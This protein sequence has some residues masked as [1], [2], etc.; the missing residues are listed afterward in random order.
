LTI[1]K[2]GNG[3]GLI[4]NKTSGSGNAVTVTGTAEATTLVKTGGVSTEFLK[5]DGSVTSLGT[6]AISLGGTANGLSY[7]NG[8]YRLH[9][10]NASNGGV[11][12][13]GRDTIAGLKI[14]R[15]SLYI[16]QPFPE[17]AGPFMLRVS[18]PLG[19]QPVSFER[20]LNPGTG[21]GRAIAYQWVSANGSPMQISD[22]LGV[23]YAGTDSAGTQTTYATIEALAKSVATNKMWGGFEDWFADGTDLKANP[24]YLTDHI[25]YAVRYPRYRD[26]SSPYMF[27]GTKTGAG[28]IKGNSFGVADSSVIYVDKNYRVG[29][30]NRTPATAFDVVGGIKSSTLGSTLVK[31]VSGV[32]TDAVASDLSS[33]GAVLTTTNQSVGGI[34]TFT[35]N[36]VFQ[37]IDPDSKVTIYPNYSGDAAGVGIQNNAGT[38]VIELNG[39]TGEIVSSTQ[40]IVSTPTTSAGGYDAL[41]RNTSTGVVEKIGMASGTYTPTLTNGT[42]VASS[43]PF[44]CQYYRI[45]NEVTVTGRIGIT[46]T[47]GSTVA[48]ELGISLPIA[49]ALTDTFDLNGGGWAT[50]YLAASPSYIQSDSGNDR[51]SFNFT[52]L[53]SASPQFTFSFT[54]IVK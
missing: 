3:E 21:L 47:S 38:F 11:L 16:G 48:T 7:L 53:A 1:T 25:P 51:A 31:S 50:N 9:K 34:K 5:A 22:G 28:I 15:D 32:L 2:G 39:S 52:A 37:G 14:I 29:I 27:Y 12:T 36:T 18:T 19:T 6:S 20:K 43:T 40:K 10:V 33:L 8:N 23:I 49:S 45:G 26:A 13:T 30:N 4:V 44:L 35:S 41:T 42:N 17:T 54:Y 24:S 46:P